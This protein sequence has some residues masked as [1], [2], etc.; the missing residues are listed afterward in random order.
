ME[1]ILRSNK[2]RVKKKVERDHYWYDSETK[3]RLHGKGGRM[4][5]V[6]DRVNKK[7]VPRIV[8]SEEY[9]YEDSY[10]DILKWIKDNN[11]DIKEKAPKRHVIVEVEPYHINDLT[12][13]LYKHRIQF[14]YDDKEHK[15]ALKEKTWQNSPSKWQIHR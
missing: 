4:I 7:S 13:D 12:E 8:D 9:V 1:L 11:L 2:R 15:K 6:Y 14:E 5:F 10:D 3:Q